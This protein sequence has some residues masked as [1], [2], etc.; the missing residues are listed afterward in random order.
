MER[1]AVCGAEEFIPYVCRYCGR[2]HCVYHRLPENHECPNINQARAPKPIIRVERRSTGANLRLIRAPKLSSISSRELYALGAALL[3]LGLSFSMRYVFS[4]LRPLEVL[5]VFL[6]TLLVIGTGFLGH[7]L[8]HKFSAQ[9][10]GCWAEFKLWTVGAIMALLF[11][12]ISQGTFIFAAP[13]AV[14]IASRSSYFGEG[15]DRKANG[16]IS[17]VGPMANIAAA[18][19]FGIALAAST[20]FGFG[21]LVI[22]HSFHFLRTGAQINIWLGAFNMIP[23]FILDGQ[24]VFTWDRKIWAAVAIPLWALVAISVLFFA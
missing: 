14:Y 6:L 16:V 2:T 4:G 24:K 11:A 17:L 21:D 5:E 18:A 23:F 15:I 8:A 12:V 19:I 9:R 3:V 10:Y 7:E 13:G 20:A 1:C 22:G